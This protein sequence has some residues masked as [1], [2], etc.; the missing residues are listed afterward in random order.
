[1][2]SEF[3]KRNS[4]FAHQGAPFSNTDMTMQSKC[5]PSK[6]VQSQCIVY[7]YRES[8]GRVNRVRV[9]LANKL[10]SVLT[11]TSPQRLSNIMSI[12]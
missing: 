8:Y 3:D 10:L 6:M 2:L 11:V 9:G 1:M 7:V 12:L 4:A 5:N